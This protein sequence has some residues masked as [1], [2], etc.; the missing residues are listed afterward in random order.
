MREKIVYKL[1]HNR[2]LNMKK[3]KVVIKV[4]IKW[5]FKYRYFKTKQPGWY[6]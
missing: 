1:S 6:I 4:V 3:K 2:C 5:L